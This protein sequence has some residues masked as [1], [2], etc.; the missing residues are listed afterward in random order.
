VRAADQFVVG[1]RQLEREAHRAPPR[2][3]WVVSPTGHL[4]LLVTVAPP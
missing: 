1:R 3:H 2:R 4:L